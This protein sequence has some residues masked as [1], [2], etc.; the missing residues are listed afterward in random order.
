MNKIEIHK[1]ICNKTHDTYKAKDADYGGAYGEVRKEF[2]NAIL[3]FL[4]IKLKRLNQLMK[5]NK[6]NVAES[7]EDT[8]IDMADYCIMELTERQFERMEAETIS[9]MERVQKLAE[10]LM[11]TEVVAKD[12]AEHFW[13]HK[14]E[15]V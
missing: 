15:Q 8:L 5:G 12:H 2:D 10:E 7:I 4:T 11:Q 1:S 6:P 14:H 3:F 9:E 13:E